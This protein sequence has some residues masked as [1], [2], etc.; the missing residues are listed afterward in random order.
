MGERPVLGVDLGGTQVRVGKV[1]DGALEGSATARISSQAAEEVVLGELFATI[2]RVFDDEVAAIGCGVPSVVD[3]ERGVVYSVENIPSWKEVH[4]AERLESRYGVPASIN[5]DAN[6][7]ALGEHRFGAGRGHRSLVGITLGTGLGA[8][9]IVEG[10]LYAGAHCGAGEIGS[11]PYREG[12]LEDA[13]AGPFFRREA[14]VSGDEVFARAEAGEAEA[15]RLYERYGFELGYAIEV[16]LY[17]YDPEIIVLGG[18]ISRAF[19]LFDGGMRERLKE[20]DYPHVLERVEIVPS[21]LE[22]AAVLGAAALCLDG[23]SNGAAG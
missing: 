10:R 19:E 1:R 11:I 23:S 9:V 14:G 21:R 16:T 3:V 17:A 18:S 15:L 6:A 2:D 8:G 13:C 20:F 12:A 4:L 7:F 5:N 22:H